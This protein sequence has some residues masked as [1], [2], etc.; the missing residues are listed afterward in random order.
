MESKELRLLLDTAFQALMSN[1]KDMIFV[2]DADLIYRAASMPFVKMVGKE[3]VDEVVG[4]TDSEILENK[5]LAKRY[6]SDDKKL[7]K[8]GKNLVDYIEPITEAEDGQA[9]FG[10]TS[11]YLLKD[12][13]GKL[14]GIVGVTKD[15]TRD[16]IARQHYQQYPL[17]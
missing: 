2:K 12:E 10:S 16:Y 11:K 9:R 5:S 1:S 6:I 13:A 7:I 14:I 4:K 8:S 15:I 3:S 17:T